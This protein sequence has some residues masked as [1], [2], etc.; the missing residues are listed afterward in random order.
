[1]IMETKLVEFSNTILHVVIDVHKRQWSVTILTKAI[2]HRTFSQPPD[3]LALKHYI[4]QHFP[5]A[6]VKC[7]YEATKLG[8]W[9]Q[10]SLEGL[11]Y[12]C[13]IVNPAD[14]PSTNR[15]SQNKADPIDSR[16]IARTL[17]GGLLK[18]LHVPSEVTQGDRQL[19]RYRKKLWGDL[20]RIKNRIKDKFL[21]SGVK[22]PDHLDNPYWT[23][24]FLR[25]V[26][27]AELPSASARLTVDLLLEQYEQ[28]YRHFLK[29]SSAVRALLKTARF[30][31][32]GKSTYSRTV[33]DRA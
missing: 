23:K 21:F 28:I 15:E 16:K 3:P 7:A 31:E 5:G 24:A 20:V 1:M 10:R 29:T 18:G 17:Q 25:W 27:Q 32:D 30:K 26:E 12:E 19:F 2:Y 8:F 33:I 6:K 14:I 9:I 22:I 11:G 4:D 13:L